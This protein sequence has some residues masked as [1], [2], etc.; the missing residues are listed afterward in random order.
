VPKIEFEG[1]SSY[2]V[3]VIDRPDGGDLLDICDEVLA[4]IPFSCRSASCATCE[5]LVLEGIEWFEPPNAE[6]ADLLE[7]LGSREHHRI[8]CQARI[9]NGSG[10]IRLRAVAFGPPVTP[11]ESP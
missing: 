3:K 5:I 10:L 9:K 4:P 1:T 6:E 2:R 11:L 8:A 7:I